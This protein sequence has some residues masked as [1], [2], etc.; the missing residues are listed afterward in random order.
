MNIKT[1]LLLTLFLG[2]L[3][4]IAALSGIAVYRMHLLSDAS[5][6]RQKRDLQG[7][8][9]TLIK[10]QVQT[11][12]SLLATLDV[13]AAKGEI[14][15][16][17]AKKEGADLIRQLRYQKDG[18]FWIDT[19]D[20]T[21]V[22]LLGKP[23][24]GKT[25]INLQ[26]VKGKYL[27]K[28]IIE[29]G[30]KDGGG[31]T[32]YWFPKAGSDTA[33][34]KRGYSL[35]FKPWGWVVGTGNYIDDIDAIVAD[36][37]KTA[38]HEL[39]QNTGFIT[40]SSLVLILAFLSIGFRFL[41]IAKT[42]NETI[43]L[44]ENNLQKSESRFRQMF[45][46]H[47]AIMMMIEPHSGRIVDANHAAETFY[48]HALDQLRNMNI[49][50]INLFPADLVAEDREHAAACEENFFVFPHR[51]SDGSVRTVEVHS[52]PIGEGDALL[53]YSIIHDI[54]DR[55]RFEE[56]L[57]SERQRLAGVIEATNAGTWEWN[58][59]TSE[60]VFNNY[61]AEIIGRRLEEISPGT[62]DTWTKF[63]HPDDLENSKDL[64]KKHFRGE[65]PFYEC[66]MRLK[67]RNGALVWIIN[68]GKI[69]RW[70]EEGK[71]LLMQG[72]HQ[73]I[74]ERK[75]SEQML[76][77]N[78]ERLLLLN[79]RLDLATMA[80]GMGVW[81]MDVNS[82]RLEWDSLMFTIYGFNSMQAPDVA[83]IRR[84]MTHPDDLS[85]QDEALRR[86][87]DGK[88]DLDT[89]FRIVLPDGEI[90][91]IKTNALLQ[92]DDAGN[93][94]RIIGVEYDI[95]K[96]KLAEEE[97]ELAKDSANAANIAKSQFLATMSH[98]IRTP[99]NGVI[100]MA[101]LLMDT[102]LNE[103]QRGYAEIVN[104]SGENLL[105]LIN[106]IL[107]FSKIEAGKLD[108]E[109]ID[110]DFRTTV[111]DTAEMLSMR[112]TLAGL[113]L[114]CDIDPQVPHYLKG[115][116]GRLRQIITNL[117]GNSIKFTH[118]GEV[119]ITARIDS[120]NEE[121][122]IIKF[123]IKDTGIGIPAN[124]IDALFSPFTQVDG[125][126]TRKYGGTGL[127]LTISKQLTELMGGKIGIISEEGRGSTFWF[128]VRL[129]RQTSDVIAIPEALKRTE[130]SGTKIL[131]V[132]DNKTNRLLMIA[133]LNHWGCPHE[134]AA[135]AM[136]GM[137][138]LREAAQQ[139][140][141]FRVALL[142]QEM[143]GMDGSELGRRIKSDPLVESTLMIMVTSL[144][145]RGDAAL[146]QQ[147][148]FVG[149]LA[150]PVRQTQL[151]NCIAIALGRANQTSSNVSTGIV[152][153][154]T[155][156]EVAQ[157]GIRILLAE[158][159][160][161]NQKVAQSILGKIG[162]KADVVANGLEA[163]RALEMIN[164]DVV[165]MDCQMPEM[166]GFEA[167]AMI[168]NT[169]SK[170]LNHAVPIIAMTANAMKGDRE[171]CIEAGMDDYLP[172]PVKKDALAALLEKWAA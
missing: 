169:E 166:D 52:T 90:R 75:K 63:V 23:I 161:I 172:K 8:Y 84:I 73:D 69:T 145:Q 142:D 65:L 72:T 159:N 111:E 128:T 91:H 96:R 9:D 36:F 160:I 56:S 16:E 131:V 60:T 86:V 50:D 4:A 106:D 68:R 28:E 138:L 5:L 34:P 6:A 37:Q 167:T 71:P 98:E 99:M 95:T 18:Y 80:A 89:E 66:E 40:I 102:D 153:K 20:G 155:V 119:A 158:D 157:R 77:F 113:E 67:H 12:V 33:L 141:P 44:A 14:P 120:E 110:F 10:S 17:E 125:S 31:Y 122:V 127:G 11:A 93:P 92:R 94:L 165:L 3:V 118:Q 168:R 104:R 139:G 144:A 101:A 26:D 35:E 149:Y 62:I 48:G 70:T 171:K 29:Q 150:K 59:L 1:K 82:G 140:N 143:P 109:V 25:R 148:G 97:L 24:E 164:Y 162:Y 22:V 15:L 137:A 115:D 30:R 61:S 146:L 32:D 163:L 78:E 83:E 46:K 41:L 121:A 53:L 58:F 126:T 151:H 76:R 135:D 147:I 42:S 49:A 129:E 81:D 105:T 54:T 19:V 79:E 116:P 123:E 100:G 85:S 7:D 170:V 87:L 132:D 74:T 88:V 108:M 124:R 152:T 21:N 103:E 117:A 134:T 39:T 114:I 45:E 154:H 57:K 38:L 107:D 51:L 47:G 156:A 136:T 13:R 133:L 130:L 64:M 2:S 27:I 43:R 112:A 55:I